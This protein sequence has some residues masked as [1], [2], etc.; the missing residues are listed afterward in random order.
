MT[1]FLDNDHN[2]KPFADQHILSLELNRLT[3]TER[4]ESPRE[5]SGRD[6]IKEMWRL[7]PDRAWLWRPKYAENWTYVP[8]D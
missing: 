7:F 4:R 5:P 2:L 6:L 3:K 8:V 1:A